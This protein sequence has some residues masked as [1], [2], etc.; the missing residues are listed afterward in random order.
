ML[1]GRQ[2]IPIQKKSL[3][4][5]EAL[6]RSHLNVNSVVVY[7]KWPCISHDTYA[8]IITNLILLASTVERCV[9]MKSLSNIISLCIYQMT[10]NYI[11]VNSTL[12]KDS[13][14]YK[15]EETSTKLFEIRRTK[16]PENHKD[17]QYCQVCRSGCRTKIVVSGKTQ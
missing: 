4:I 10:R 16:R 11:S 5:T 13:Y 1:Q 8:Y 3:M 17:R 2:L 6:L 7:L 12:V 9:K 14:Q 15:S